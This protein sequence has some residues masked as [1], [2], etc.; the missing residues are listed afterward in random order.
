MNDQQIQTLAEQLIAAIQA[1]APGGPGWWTIVAAF[2]SYATLAAAVVAFFIG[3]KTLRGQKKALAVQIAASESSLT[4]Q[5]AALSAQIASSTSNLI[6]QQKVLT[7]QDA[8]NASNLEQRREADA[9]SEWW[10]R[11]QWA[12]EAAASEGATMYAYGTGMLQVLVT[13]DLASSEDKKLL[14][15]VWEGTSTEM[16]DGDIEQLFEEARDQEG[17]TD[18]QLMTLRSYFVDENDQQG[19]VVSAPVDDEPGSVE[20]GSS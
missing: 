8:A 2:G 10:R 3:L 11:T 20:N 12:L 15:A 18:E 9:R 5:Q 4:Q 1:L 13:S 19:P 6:Q 17:L 14:D 16:Q 7:A